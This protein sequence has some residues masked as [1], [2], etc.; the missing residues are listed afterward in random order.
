[1]YRYNNERRHS[2]FN[3]L[4]LVQKLL[5]LEIEL[6]LKE[7]SKSQELSAENNQGRPADKELKIINLLSNHFITEVVG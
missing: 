7:N 2:G 3:Y 4:I 6:T 1:M 5:K